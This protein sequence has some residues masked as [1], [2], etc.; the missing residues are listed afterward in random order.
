MFAIHSIKKA[1]LKLTW[2]IG[3]AINQFTLS[4]QKTCAGSSDIPRAIKLK[5]GVIIME[6]CNNVFYNINPTCLWRVNDFAMITK[7][8]I[9][10]RIK[11]RICKYLHYL[12]FFQAIDY[13]KFILSIM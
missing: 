7:F 3:P 5:L 6:P 12:K 10:N 2:V 13:N 9:E 11:T 8:Y 4:I 1:V